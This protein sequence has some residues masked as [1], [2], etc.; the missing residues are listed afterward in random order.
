M[1]RPRRCRDQLGFGKMCPGLLLISSGSTQTTPVH[2]F[3]RRAARLRGNTNRS[4]ANRIDVPLPL[5][6]RPANRPPPRITTAN[7]TAFCSPPTATSFPPPNIIIPCQTGSHP[8]PLLYLRYRQS[9]TALAKLGLLETRRVSE[10][11]C[12]RCSPT[13]ICPVCRHH[14]PGQLLAAS[15]SR[16][17]LPQ[18]GI[19]RG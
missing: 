9:H 7:A 17:Q 11:W 16:A 5:W 2:Y 6:Q 10:I 18:L 4:A 12:P 15:A 8:P 13:P 14:S 19:R 1:T 3:P